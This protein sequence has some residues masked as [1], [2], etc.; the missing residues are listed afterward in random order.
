MRIRHYLYNAFVITDGDLKLAI[1]PGRNLRLPKLGSLIPRSEWDRTT[2]VLVTHGDPDHFP[3][4]VPM[5]LET[6]ATVVC[7]NDLVEERSER[8]PP[9]IGSRSRPCRRPTALCTSSSC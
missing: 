1:D 7:G 3:Y 6:G 9:S 4:A 8:R 2:H 5:A